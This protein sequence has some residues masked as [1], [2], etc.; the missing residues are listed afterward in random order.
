MKH[1]ATALFL[2]LLAGASPAAAADQAMFCKAMQK[3]IM[4]PESFAIFIKQD[5]IAYVDEQNAYYINYRVKFERG[6]E[7]TTEAVHENGEVL[8]EIYFNKSI[9]TAT[10]AAG[11]K[12]KYACKGTPT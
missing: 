5:K 12:G 6:P 8:V 1:I 11:V 2:T 7:L 3:D 10:F 9:I 4:A